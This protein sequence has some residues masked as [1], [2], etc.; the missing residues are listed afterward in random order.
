MADKEESRGKYVTITNLQN[1]LH[2]LSLPSAV[3]NLG[4]E[5]ICYTV[6]MYY[7]FTLPAQQ[8]APRPKSRRMALRPSPTTLGYA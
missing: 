1:T 6:F 2:L 7:I 5:K 3:I 4:P 8:C